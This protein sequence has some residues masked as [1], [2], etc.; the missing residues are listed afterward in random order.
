MPADGTIAAHLTLGGL[1]ARPLAA[2]HPVYTISPSVEKG[3]ARLVLLAPRGEVRGWPKLQST[4]PVIALGSLGRDPQRRA[5][6]PPR[7]RRSAMKSQR[8]IIRSPRRQSRVWIP[9]RLSGESWPSRCSRPSQT[10][11]G[12][13][14]EALPA[15]RHAECDRHREQRGE[16]DQH[17]QFRM[18]ANHLLLQM[19]C[20]NK[21]PVRCFFGLPI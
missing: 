11:L 10:L 4:A 9:A 19:S 2:R 6:L 8:R 18:Q 20:H 13:A 1:S 21:R 5:T 14:Q 15:L 12:P 7:H 16:T 3:I 17:D